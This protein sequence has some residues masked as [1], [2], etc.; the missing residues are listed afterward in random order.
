LDFSVPQWAAYVASW[1]G[2]VAGVWALF[3]RAETVINEPTRRSISAWLKNVGAPGA[4]SWTTDFYYVFRRFFG[5]RHWSWRCFLTSAVTSTVSLGLLVLFGSAMGWWFGGQ[6]LVDEIVAVLVVAAVLNLLP[7]YLALLK[8]RFTLRWL[9]AAKAR[10][11]IAALL[12]ADAIVTGLIFVFFATLV[13]M[14]I[15]LWQ[16]PQLVN[17]SGPLEIEF[18]PR[19]TPRDALAALL[20]TP[21]PASIL[22]TYLTSVWLWLY[23]ISGFAAKAIAAL[24][25]G[26]RTAGNVLDIDK[27]PLRSI[28]F[29]AMGIVTLVFLLIPIGRLIT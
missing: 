11:K 21:V 13:A 4:S 20:A 2:L 6:S 8:T 19:P 25:S 1:L 29:V 18:R 27:Q 23:V 12:L 3:E 28:G 24:R 14:L 5:E 16:E 22:T 26:V 10:W 7:D 9:V 15:Q 17:L